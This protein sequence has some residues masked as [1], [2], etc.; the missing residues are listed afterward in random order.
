MKISSRMTAV[1]F[2]KSMR[3]SCNGL[4]LYFSLLDC[5]IRIVTAVYV[6]T[7]STREENYLFNFFGLVNTVN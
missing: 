3:R 6:F 2:S 5:I 1:V 4:G 7:G